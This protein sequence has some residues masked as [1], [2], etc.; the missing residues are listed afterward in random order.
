MIPMPRSKPDSV[1]THRFE[2]GDFERKQIKEVADTA[3]TLKLGLAASSI[4]GAGALA[5]T[6]YGLWWFFDSREEITQRINDSGWI[7]D[8]WIVDEDDPWYYDTPWT[9]PVFFWSRQFQR[10]FGLGKD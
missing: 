5:V 10:L 2:F 8:R 7:G 4:V 6:A 1:M 9:N 3:K